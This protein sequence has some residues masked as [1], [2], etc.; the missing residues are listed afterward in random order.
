VYRN[1]ALADGYLGLRAEGL[2]A[3]RKAVE[4]DRFD[5]ANQ[6]VLA[7]FEQVT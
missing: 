1:L 5:V 3:A 7:E 2:A 4:L 6:A